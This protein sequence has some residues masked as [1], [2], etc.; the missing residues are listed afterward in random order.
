MKLS[1][2]LEHLEKTRA[3]ATLRESGGEMTEERKLELISILAKRF[4]KFQK[5][6]PGTTD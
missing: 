3:E 2:R 4:E 1:N 6:P 5:P